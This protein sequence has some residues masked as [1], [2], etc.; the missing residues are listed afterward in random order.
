MFVQVWRNWKSFSTDLLMSGKYNLFHPSIPRERSISRWLLFHSLFVWY[1]SGLT[2]DS[3]S[4]SWNGH[5]VITLICMKIFIS[6][7]KYMKLFDFR[8]QNSIGLKK[9]FKMNIVSR[10]WTDY[11]GD[12]KWRTLQYLKLFILKLLTNRENRIENIQFKIHPEF[13]FHLDL[14]WVEKSKVRFEL[15]FSFIIS[16]KHFSYLP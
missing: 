10:H 4:L 16:K 8:F 11:T 1:R 12:A 5:V 2:W 6:W 7:R 9:T 14:S 15:H 13:N 3:P